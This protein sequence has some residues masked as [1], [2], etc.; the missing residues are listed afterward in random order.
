M[1]F[2]LDVCIPHFP[3]LGG[4]V[5]FSGLTSEETIFQKDIMRYYFSV[6]SPRKNINN[7]K[8]K[9]EKRNTYFIFCLIFFLCCKFID[10]FSYFLGKFICL[11]FF[12]IKILRQNSLSRELKIRVVGLMFKCSLHISKC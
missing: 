10:L 6:R 12:Q 4:A 9:K 7:C 8:K 11:L 2:G 3:F 5:L 1:Q